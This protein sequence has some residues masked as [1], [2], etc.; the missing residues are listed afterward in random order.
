MRKARFPL[1]TERAFP[2]FIAAL[3]MFV[4]ARECIAAGYINGGASWARYGNRLS[5]AVPFERSQGQA[6]SAGFDIG[7]GLTGGLVFEMGIAQSPAFDGT[8]Q[9]TG[10]ALEKSFLDR[11]LTFGVAVAMANI[12]MGP[13]A[14]WS[15]CPL[16]DLYVRVAMVRFQKSALEAM[17]GARSI[18]VA[19]TDSLVAGRIGITAMG[20]L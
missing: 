12:D 4:S 3:F 1:R 20:F 16:G 6:I 9:A 10:F 7:G 14:V 2:V 19:R 17:A 11:A 15:L 8:Y 5:S 18:I 13:G